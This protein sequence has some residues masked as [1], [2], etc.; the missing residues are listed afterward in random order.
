MINLSAN[1]FDKT[2][3]CLRNVVIKSSIVGS[4]RITS[5][6]KGKKVLGL[7]REYKGVKSYY[8]NLGE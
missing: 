8:T 4:A 5:Y 1:E 3:R 7:V 2:I 6:F